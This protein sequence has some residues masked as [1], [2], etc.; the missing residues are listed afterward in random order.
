MH[1]GTFCGS[2]DESREHLVELVEVLLDDPSLPAEA[3]LA[4][5]SMSKEDETKTEAGG[6]RSVLDLR[7]SWKAGFG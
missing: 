3:T 5:K 6:R 4:E 2:E 7:E 1:F